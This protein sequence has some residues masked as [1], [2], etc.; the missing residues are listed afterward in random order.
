[1]TTERSFFYT[2]AFFIGLEPI[3][4]C[5]DL[6]LR[7]YYEFVVISLGFKQLVCDS[8]NQIFLSD[9]I[10]QDWKRSGEWYLRN[11]IKGEQAVSIKYQIGGNARTYLSSKVNSLK[12]SLKD[13]P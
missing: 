7:V 13:I 4:F 6:T 5:S 2:K 3:F 11:N 9:W 10:I 8:Y 1:M 12:I